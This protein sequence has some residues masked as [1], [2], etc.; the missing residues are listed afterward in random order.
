MGKMS[1]IRTG[2]VMPVEFSHRLKEGDLRSCATKVEFISGMRR[3]P[4]AVSV[5]TTNWEGKRF[6]LTATAVCSLSAE[7]PRL[8]ACVNLTGA[9]FAA[10][11]SAGAFAVN[12]LTIDQLSVGTAFAGQPDGGKDRFEDGSW[13]ES[14]NLGV[15]TLDD[16]N[17]AFECVVSEIIDSGSHGIIIGDVVSV[18]HKRAGAP[19]IYNDG[20]FCGL[21]R[22]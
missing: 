8:L 6:G 11:R 1:E 4:G 19:L 21:L 2:N 7:P 3:F 22:L 5:I 17:C 13:S 16:A 18:P 15:P 12:S 9:S 10:I 14:A 20:V